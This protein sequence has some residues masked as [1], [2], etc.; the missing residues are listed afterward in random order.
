MA[1][2]VAHLGV[3]K[4]TNFQQGPSAILAVSIQQQVLQLEIPVGHALQSTLHSEDCKLYQT[5][6]TVPAILLAV[7]NYMQHM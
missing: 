5:T 7:C 4:V 6:I 3:A 1:K 2:E